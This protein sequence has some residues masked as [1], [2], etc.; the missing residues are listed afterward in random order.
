LLVEAKMM[1]LILK[2]IN[3]PESPLLTSPTLPAMEY[4]SLPHSLPVY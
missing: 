2:L 1:L 4:C 3:Q